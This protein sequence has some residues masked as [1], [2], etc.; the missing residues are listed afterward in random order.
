MP[1]VWPQKAKKKK[2][3]KKIS[4]REFEWPTALTLTTPK[5]HENVGQW[6][7]HSFWWECKMVPATW[8][9]SL[10]VSYKN[11]YT[12]T[13]WS[14][15]CVA[16]YLSKGVSSVH[17]HKNRHTNIY[18]SSRRNCQNSGAAR[19]SSSGWV[20]KQNAV[21]PG[22]RM[23]FSAKKK[24]AIRPWSNLKCMLL[25]ERSTLRRLGAERFQLYDSLE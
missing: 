3:K 21:H 24:W 20:D 1:C 18:S 22:K 17:L 4:P 16:W 15:N 6:N 13:V 19:M 14:S 7:C 12:L 2:K 25:R 5:A 10:M 8:G 23:F 11:K 9:A